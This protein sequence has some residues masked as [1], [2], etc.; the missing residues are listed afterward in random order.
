MYEYMMS[1]VGEHAIRT[2]AKFCLYK[3]IH[4]L[5]VY[6]YVESGHT[7]VKLP[8]QTEV[9]FSTAPSQVNHARYGYGNI[10]T[11][12]AILTTPEHHNFYYKMSAFQDLSP[13]SIVFYEIINMYCTH[14]IIIFNIADSIR[15]QT[16]H[17]LLCAKHVN[18]INYLLSR[19]K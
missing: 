5:H 14:Y 1:S 11:S 19:C 3:W 13:Y 9:R 12:V 4:I 17:L 16:D 18:F 8:Q 10:F 2:R 6:S 15:W 7:R